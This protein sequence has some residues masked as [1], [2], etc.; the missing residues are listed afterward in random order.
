[1]SL[2]TFAFALL[3]TYRKIARFFLK[4]SRKSEED[5][6]YKRIVKGTAWE[7]FCEGLKA[8]GAVLLTPDIPK[9]QLNQAEGY[10]YLTRLLRARLQ[11]AC[12][13]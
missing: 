13:H 5:I 11:T 8:A 1:M 4:I 12:A 2:K 7:E 6:H 10:R 3:N 9:D